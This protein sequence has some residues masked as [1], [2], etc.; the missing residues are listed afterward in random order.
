MKFP[1]SRPVLLG[2]GQAA[3]LIGFWLVLELFSRWGHWPI[4]A[5][6]V[7]VLALWAMLDRGW[8]PLG[9]VEQGAD[10]LLEHLLLFFV[11]A[12]LGLLNHPEFLSLLGLKLLAA[13]LLGT[14]VVMGGTAAVVEW[15]FRLENRHAA[16][17]A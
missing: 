17:R 6:V 5:S 14:L 16:D 10:R 2:G 1:I 15:G 3:A 13:V 9:W 8:V 7:G 12:M 4:P 11:P